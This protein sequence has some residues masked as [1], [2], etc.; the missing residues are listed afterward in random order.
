MRRGMRRSELG[1]CAPNPEDP[2]AVVWTVWA[3]VEEK[4]AGARKWP[5]ALLGWGFLLYPE[6]WS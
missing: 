4:E 5:A 6:H 2:A 1:W 3:E